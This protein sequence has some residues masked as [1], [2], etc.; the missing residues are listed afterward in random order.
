MKATMRYMSICIFP[1]GDCSIILIFS[2]KEDTK[3]L[4]SFIESFK[5]LSEREKGKCLLAIVMGHTSEQLFL[6]KK[7]YEKL[8]N[9]D[10][11]NHFTSMNIAGNKDSVMGNF[12]I[13]GTERVKLTRFREFPD[14][15]LNSFY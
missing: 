1:M 7:S 13:G 8:T 6:N 14:I 12:I 10:V 9:L 2:L 15:F 4:K 11:S 5:K 3:Y